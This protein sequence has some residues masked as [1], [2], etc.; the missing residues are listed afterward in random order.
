[1]TELSDALAGTNRRIGDA[2]LD[3][4]GAQV[5]MSNEHY[6]VHA[7]NMWEF[8]IESR[9]LAQNGLV[10][11]QIQTGLNALHLKELRVWGDAAEA[12]FEIIEAPTLTTGSSAVPMI[13]MNRAD[14]APAP[15]GVT[16]FSDPTGISAGTSLMSRLF[17]G[18][19][20]VGQTAFA[21]TDK[22]DRER[23]LAPSSRYLLRLTNLEANA[24][25][26][27]IDGAFYLDVD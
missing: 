8:F 21:G 19:A 9:A 6:M 14:G 12:R 26:F 23:E 16:M 11:V 3:E 22:T 27:S 15:T 10:L 4:S 24:R 7:S 18:G 25:N 13:N 5:T 2:I 20:G 17:G 1:M